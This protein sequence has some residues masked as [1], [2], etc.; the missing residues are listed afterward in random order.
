VYDTIGSDQVEGWDQAKLRAT[1]K[2]AG[3]PP[4]ADKARST[5]S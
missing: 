3:A 4:S 5:G 1:L 2:E